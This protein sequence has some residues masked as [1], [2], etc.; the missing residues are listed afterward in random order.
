MRRRLDLAASLVGEPPVLFL[1]EPTT[2]LDP[3]GRNDV[4]TLLRELIDT[5]TTLVLTT[6]YLEE[7]DRLADTIAVLDRGR[8]IANGPPAELKARVGGD[9]IAVTLAS[10]EGLLG[11][12]EALQAFADG[13]A[14]VDADQP[15]VTV[16]VRA[17]TRLVEV[18]H[19]LDTA[20]VDAIDV[21]R[22]EATLDD[23]FLTLT[24]T[25]PEPVG[26]PAE[27]RAT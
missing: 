24:G 1:D 18:V 9:R 10:R 17:G 26:E 16:P 22:R 23:V 11:A 27:V 5:G 15:R 14:I 20:D 6:Q 19:A 7:A 12:A 3:Q 4:W 21:H 13:Q 2:G 25:Q 8:I